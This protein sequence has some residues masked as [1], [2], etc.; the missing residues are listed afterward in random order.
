MIEGLRLEPRVV[1][2]GEV[3]FDGFAARLKA[4]ANREHRGL[5]SSE[6]DIPPRAWFY[7]GRRIFEMHLVPQWFNSREAKDFLTQQ[8]VKM[9]GAL[10]LLEKVGFGQE[11]TGVNYVGLLYGMVGTVVNFDE[12][13]SEE[14]EYVQRGEIPPTRTAPLDDP[15]AVESLNAIVIDREI[16]KAWVAPINRKRGRPPRL[17]SWEPLEELGGMPSGLMIDPIKEAMR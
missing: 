17:S 7:V 15:D 1:H 16:Q 11:A 13:T 9:V 3:S 14:L 12:L 4:A 2:R 6:G 5:R 8:I 10:P